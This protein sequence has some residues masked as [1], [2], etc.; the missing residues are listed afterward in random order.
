MS[1][2]AHVSE[3]PP[4]P[5]SRVKQIA[6]V[7]RAIAGRKPAS[8]KAQTVAA[9]AG[10]LATVAARDAKIV[11]LA[12]E[13]FTTEAIAE[14]LG[15]SESLV[16]Q[17]RAEHGV[18]APKPR[19]GSGF[20]ARAETSHC[21]KCGSLIA[22]ALVLGQ[23]VIVDAEVRQVITYRRGTRDGVRVDA[24]APHGERCQR[25]QLER[26]LAAERAARRGE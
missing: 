2:E 3:S 14:Q 7:A 16:R 5:P 4:K 6:R 13:G 1:M 24:R 18:A 8:A 20:A 9:I 12:R 25:I 26:Q 11:E 15:Y 19:G 10:S 17:V 22:V 23:P 21:V